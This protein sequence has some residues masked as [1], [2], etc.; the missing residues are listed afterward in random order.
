MKYSNL[1][2]KKKILH[3]YVGR[4]IEKIIAESEGREVK[5]VIKLNEKAGCPLSARE[6]L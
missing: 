1:N 5:E 6:K 3:T 2:T 4:G